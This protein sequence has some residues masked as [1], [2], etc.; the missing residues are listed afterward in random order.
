MRMLG[1]I[2]IDKH[3]FNKRK[4][5]KHKGLAHIKL[6]FANRYEN[7]FLCIDLLFTFPLFTCA[8]FMMARF[9]LSKNYIRE[10]NAI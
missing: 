7:H 8:K 1:L 10:F 9:S 5:L 3:A 4:I 2:W 6:P